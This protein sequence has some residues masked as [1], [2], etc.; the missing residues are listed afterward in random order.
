MLLDR[1]VDACFVRL[2]AYVYTN[3]RG[4]VDWAG[5]HSN[6]FPIKNGV[7]QGAI[8]SPFLFNIYIDEITAKLKNSTYGC[9]FGMNFVGV[10]EYADDIVIL[11]PSLRGLRKMLAI[12]SDHFGGLDL[13]FNAKK[14]FA[15][16][17]GTPKVKQFQLLLDGIQIPF[18]DKV[19]YYLGVVLVNS[20]DDTAHILKL[21]GLFYAS[22]NAL[23][24]TFKGLDSDILFELFSSYCCTYYG[25]MC[26]SLRSRNLDKLYVAWNKSVRRIFR[27]P[28]RTHT[29]IL[30]AI[31][32]KPHIHRACLVHFTNFSHKLLKSGNPILRSLAYKSFF[33]QSFYFE[34]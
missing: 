6:F 29:N 30:P 34:Y 23:F 33:L 19:T 2:L 27:L 22:A 11:C 3:Q 16:C 31:I 7:R 10:F 1:G 25:L 18:V 14:S 8:L 13:H 15:V 26:C 4:V 12:C 28:Y 5:T 9:W 21:L 17:F 32:G 20:L 24:V